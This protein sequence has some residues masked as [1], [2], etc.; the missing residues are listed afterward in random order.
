VYFHFPT[1]FTSNSSE[2]KNSG[3]YNLHRCK[4]LLI[5]VRFY[6]NLNFLRFQSKNP[7]IKYRE[8]TSNG[9]RGI[10]CGQKR[11]DDGAYSLFFFFSNLRTRLKNPKYTHCELNVLSKCRYL[12]TWLRLISMWKYLFK[13]VPFLYYKNYTS[14]DCPST[15]HQR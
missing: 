15:K 9:S 5:V 8:N 13:R 6:A 1:A 4:V 2:P 11:K 7:N 10:P 12:V 3:R 14:S